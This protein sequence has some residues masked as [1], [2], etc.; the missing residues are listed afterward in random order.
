MA[1][2]ERQLEV[3]S[4][5]GTIP[6]SKNT[7]HTI[8]NVL[9]SPDSGFSRKDYSIFLQGS[10]GNDTNIYSESDVDIVIKLNS[11]FYRNL[12][13]LPEYQKNNFFN[14]FPPMS[15]SYQDFKEDVMK[16]LVNNFGSFVEEGKKAIKINGYGNRRNADVL[17]AAD[18]REYYTFE[19]FENSNYL[20]GIFFITTDGKEIT[21]YPRQHSENC[22]NKHQTTN[23]YFKPMVRILKNMRGRL[24]EKGIIEKK[25]APSYFI[26][27]LLYNVPSEKFGKSYVE[28]FLNCFRWIGQANPTE[29]ICA[30]REFYLIRDGFDI[31]WPVENYKK[32]LDSIIDFWE[33][34]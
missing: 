7:Y 3:W 6:Q 4:H 9:E 15:Y 16:L 20:S 12:E 17:V 34:Y 22:T 27:G 30:N 26:E 29:F 23:Y 2:P 31:T 28:T 32:F 10:Y 25:I 19:S 33:T 18:W 1:I 24:V 5:Q 13:R 21:N 8:K 14:I 11:T